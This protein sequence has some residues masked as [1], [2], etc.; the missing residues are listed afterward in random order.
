MYRNAA[1]ALDGGIVKAASRIGA[2]VIIKVMAYRGVSTG[3]ENGGSA[4]SQQ[5]AEMAIHHGGNGYIGCGGIGEKRIQRGG[6]SAGGWRGN[7]MA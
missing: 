4:G 5:H 1:S 6:G 3:G 2:G 7:E